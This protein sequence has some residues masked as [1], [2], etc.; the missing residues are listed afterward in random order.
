MPRHSLVA[1]WVEDLELSL[2]QLKLLLW[3]RFDTWPR[4]LHR[5]GQ[6]KKKYTKP[7]LFVAWTF[8]NRETK[9]LWSRTAVKL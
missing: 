4:N 8:T 2:Q 7:S 9:K 3:L 5:R 6:K 1:Q